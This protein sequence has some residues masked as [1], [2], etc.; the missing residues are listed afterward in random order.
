MPKFSLRNAIT[1]LYGVGA[2]SG[3]VGAITFHEPIF[4]LFTYVCVAQMSCY[5]DLVAKSW[6]QSGGRISFEKYFFSHLLWIVS[7]PMSWTWVRQNAIHISQQKVVT[8]EMLRD[9]PALASDLE[10]AKKLK[11]I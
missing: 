10:Q 6:L 7:I 1:Q 8:P 11:I 5:L 2:A 4:L 9:K 3:F